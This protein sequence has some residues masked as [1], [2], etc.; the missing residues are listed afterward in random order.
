MV[1]LNAPARQAL[2]AWLRLRDHAPADF[3]AGAA[4]RGPGRPLAVSRRQPRGAT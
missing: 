3:G 1:P 4:G 2:A